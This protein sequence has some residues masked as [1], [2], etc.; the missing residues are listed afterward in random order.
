MPKQAFVN[1]RS[2]KTQKKLTCLLGLWDNAWL[3]DSR[4][5]PSI[6][7][8]I[9]EYEMATHSSILVWKIPWTNEP[10]GLQS[11]ELQRVGHN[12]GS[13]HTPKSQSSFSSFRKVHRGTRGDSPEEATLDLVLKERKENIQMKWGKGMFEKENTVYVTWW[14]WERGWGMMKE[15]VGRLEEI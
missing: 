3:E 1:Q 11:M 7:K 5:H 10:G 4:E 2:V 14:Q 8:R 13:T 9:H 12:W 15:E 6:H